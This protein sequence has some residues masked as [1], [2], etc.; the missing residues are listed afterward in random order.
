MWDIYV[1]VST[2]RADRDYTGCSLVNVQN[3]SFLRVANSLE[4]LMGSTAQLAE[5]IK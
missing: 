5:L 3:I 2:V 4:L 1:N